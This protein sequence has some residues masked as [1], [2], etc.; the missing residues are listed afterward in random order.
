MREPLR[1]LDGC[2]VRVRPQREERELRHLLGSGVGELLT[3]MTHLD[4]EQARETVEVAVALVVVD[5]GAVAAHDDRD[6]PALLVGG[7]AREV[8]PEVVARRVGEAVGP[9]LAHVLR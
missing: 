5:V 3:S 4:G 2:R 8:H 7:V 6:V 9:G 1:Q